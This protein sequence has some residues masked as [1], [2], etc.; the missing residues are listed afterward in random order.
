MKQSPLGKNGPMVSA[1]R[2]CLYGHVLVLR[3]ARRCGVDC[4]GS[5]RLSLASTF[6]IRPTFMAG[7]NDELLGRAIRGRRDELVL[8]T[9]P[10]GR[11]ELYDLV[12]ERVPEMGK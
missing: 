1:N 2:P 7:A 6:S 11:A 8:A 9:K 5:S 4:N 10:L 12:F 3:T